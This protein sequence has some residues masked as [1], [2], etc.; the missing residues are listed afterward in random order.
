MTT[1]I[2]TDNIQAATL[3]T[4]GSAP[5]ITSVVVTDSSYNN[6]DDTAV[7]TAG[8]YIKITGTGFKTG[9]TVTIN[10]QPA[11]SVT[12]VSSTELRA[13]VAAEVAG[14]YVVYVVNTDGSVALRVNGITFSALPS[15]TTASTLP[16]SDS[17]T[18]ISIQLA[19]AQA[20]TYSVAAGSTLPSGLS[21]SS[22][23]LLTGTINVANETLY[24]FSVVATDAELQDSPRSFSINITVGDPLFAQTTLL[25]TGRANTFVSDSST[26][27][28]AL[29]VAGDTKPSNFN[30]Y[31]SQYSAQFTA[32][33]SYVSVPATTALTTYTGDF[34][35][36]AW[37]YPSDT[38]IT[39]W[40]IWDSRQSGATAQAM[41][42]NIE[43]LATPVTG[44]GRLKYFN[45]TS[46]YSTGTIF[47]NRWTHVAFVRSGTTLTFYVDG[48]ASGT[49]TV[50]GTQSG[51]ATT[52]PIW[53]GSKD[54]GNA[55]YGTTGF[56]SNLRVVNGTAVYASNFTPPTTPLTAVTN[57]ALLAFQN[58][59]YSDAS[60]NAYTLTPSG[61]SISAFSPF[62]QTAATSGSGYFDGTG[63]WLTAPY[64]SL[65]SLG[66]TYTIEA[67]VYPTV[68]NTTNH[69]IFNILNPT[70]T[71]FGGCIFYVNA[72]GVLYFETRPGTGGVN[73][74]LNG[75]TVP[76]NTWTHVCVSVSSGAAK[77]FVNG[78]QVDSD[79]VVALNGT[80]SHV[81]IGAFTNGFTAYPWFGYISNL[82]VVK[83]TA[84]Y[85]ANFTPPASPLTAVSGTSLLTLQ[86]S[87][88]HNNS[89]FLDSSGNNL[90]I[91]RAGN[92]TQGSF[93]PYSPSGWSNYFGTTAMGIQTP[94]SSLTNIIGTSTLAS[95]STFTI[96]A[97]INPASR[98]SGSA[99]QQGFVA[100]SMNITGGT[101][102]WGFGPD[103]NGLL[104]VWWWN[105][106]S[107]V[108]AATTNAVPLNTWTHIATT[109]SSGVIR[110]FINGV[111]ETLTGTT[112]V[113]SVASALSY[114][115]VGGYTAGGTT[116]Q[117]F[118]GYI[119]NLRVVRSALYT[120]NFTPSTQP[121]T[122]ITGTTLLTCCDNRFIDES[123]NNF[124]I[125]RTNDV[126][127]VN[128]SPHK[129]VLQTP[130]SYSTYF[131]GSGDYLTLPSNQTQF[132]MSTGD[133][134]IEMW[135]YITSLAS[136]RTIYDTMNS[137]DTTGTGR[138]AI[139]VATSGTV[140]VF[141]GAGAIL[142]SGGTVAA[143]AWA[144]IAY[145]KASNSGKLYV[146][147][148]QVNTTYTDNNNYVVGTTNRPIIGV[149]AYDNSTNPMLGCIS[150]LRI[151]KDTAIY[152]ANFTP[153]TQPLTAISG[154]SLLT[155]QNANFVDNS[156]N[157]FALTVSGNPIPAT[158]NPFGT[159]FVNSS[160]YTAAEYSGS[161]YFDG[162]GDYLEL[163]ANTI[164]DFGSSN[165]TIEC[166]V[167]PL[168]T[169]V[170]TGFIANW[171][172][173]GQFIFR[174]TTANRLQ[175][176]YDP[177]SVAAVTVTGTTT[178]I[179]TGAWNHVAVVRN[180]SLYTMY[181]N[182][183]A[184]ATTSTSAAALEVLGKPLRIGDAGDLTGLMNGYISDSRIIRGQALYTSN[185]VPPVAPLTPVTNT[186]ML[187][188]G[189]SAGIVD[190]TTK[191]NVE[192][193]G[194]VRVSSAV[195]KF[196]G[197]SM[198]FD[199]T[200]DYLAV[201]NNPLFAFGTG[202]FT[203]EFWFYPSVIN[204]TN[205]PI[206]DTRT[207]SGSSSGLLIRVGDGGVSN[208][209]YMYAVVGSTSIFQT[210]LSAGQ[211]HHIA[212]TRAGTSCKV[213]IN[214]LGGTAGTS[215]A[216][217][218]TNGLLISRFID[219]G[220]AING[221]L[222][223]LR[224][225]K[226]TARYTA[227]FTPPTSAFNIK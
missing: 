88:S 2:S 104:S 3:A 77:L 113:T 116:W 40:G 67:W 62:A 209:T 159:T 52:N 150:N 57:T 184:D 153:P 149:N 64:S 220:N 73:I 5:R 59:R 217:L 173:G 169:G 92:A 50:S 115:T 151:V 187:V 131:D 189:T 204:L 105:G 145:T 212:V 165:F 14:T 227:N 55:S 152:T 87:V 46:Y 36:E 32:K 160:G 178:T 65:F 114:F 214:G 163:P 69:E 185:F 39:Y 30:P 119:S 112:T 200:G 121:L 70:V 125:T 205:N 158:V 123:P 25:L 196:G 198:Y 103:S 98:H 171:Q 6:L 218:T 146:N 168:T 31:L 33:T 26:N 206:V 43:P 1:Q 222:Q 58:N 193:V 74:A 143:G 221:Y 89:Q 192:T 172:S 66:N 13:Q 117:G 174:K 216:N 128:F 22:G 91:T 44:R 139:Q 142:T 181:V 28:L 166:W 102:D 207:T 223:D 224:I 18:A 81:G 51:T 82:R 157:S 109:I 10:R 27:N 203:V 15:W 48:V 24:N 38:T 179:I 42:F 111:Q 76:L 164:F 75:G 129:A 122:A 41:A 175:F 78:T 93:S 186:T 127:V 156:T 126:R 134:T 133:F 141:T 21:L 180:G 147:G 197:S 108:R 161:M 138:F 195:S 107:I 29:T 96:E 90:L 95:T 79:T 47:Y 219:S 8:G 100:G 53:I 118:N 34:T 17:G 54:N 56:I 183:V 20:T 170:L 7:D 136:T 11:T 226:G 177:V 137:G 71:N 140:Q 86:N 201:A 132:S 68:L 19:A 23:G 167:F 154:T 49:A 37:V 148:I 85:T 144:H 202:D 45:G 190:A 101:A 130:V 124:A 176:V 106:G 225:T 120:A 80:Q 213:W 211:W 162:T 155:C 191:N 61:T 83:G 215:S 194:D 188:N 110:I 135:V 210:G 97:W 35:F 208:P 4:I 199:G 84:I 12:F 63:D 16:T 60:A 99:A 94:A 9:A 72:S 182:G